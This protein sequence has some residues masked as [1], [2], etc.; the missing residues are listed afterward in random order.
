MVSGRDFR[1]RPAHLVPGFDPNVV[2]VSG[3]LAGL[4]LAFQRDRLVP[5]IRSR[6]DGVYFGIGP[7]EQALPS[8][9][10]TAFQIDFTAMGIGAAAIRFEDGA[11]RGR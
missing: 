1:K 2:N 7:L 8:G 11:S 3:N 5:S 9:N 4:R 10:F 6:R